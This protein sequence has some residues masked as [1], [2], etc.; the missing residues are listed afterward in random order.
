M[1][2][3]NS[4]TC[5][6]SLQ[7]DGILADEV[8]AA[9]VAVEVHPHAGPVEPRRHLLDVGG[10]AGAVQALQHHAAVARKAGEDGQR[11]IG[12]EAVDGVDLGHVGIALGEGR[13]HQVG[14]DAEQL[15]HRDAL[16]RP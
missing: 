6:P 7:H 16:R 8:E 9:D 13:H 1:P 12:V 11:D 14:I 3:W 10:F 2:S 5:R 15:A 4:V